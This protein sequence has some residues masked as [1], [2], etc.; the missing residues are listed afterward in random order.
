MTKEE[1]IRHIIQTAD[2]WGEFVTGDDGFV[3]WWPDS[4]RGCFNPFALRVL[5][6]ELDRRNEPWKKQID[7]YFEQ[8][9]RG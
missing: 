4:K 8:Q 9:K 7:E 1:Q 6:D 5:A 3:Y 2:K